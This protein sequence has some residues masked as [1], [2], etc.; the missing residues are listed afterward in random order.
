MISYYKRPSFLTFSILINLVLLYFTT[1]SINEVLSQDLKGDSRKSLVVNRVESSNN[2]KSDNYYLLVCNDGIS[3]NIEILNSFKTVKRLSSDSLIVFSAELAEKMP[4]I[5]SNNIAL[6][7]VNNNWKVS[8]NITKSYNKLLNGDFWLKITDRQKWEMFDDSKST[9]NTISVH[10]GYYKV[11]IDNL[12]FQELLN[13]SYITYIE[14]ASDTI[15]SEARVLD[16]NLNPN[17][18]NTIQAYFPDMDG[19]GEFVS[20]KEPFYEVDDIDLIGRYFDTGRESEFSDTHSLEMATIIAGNGN[21]FLTGLGVAPK[22]FHTSS[23]NSE[24]VPDP[25][26]YFASNKIQTQN[27]SYGTGIESFY[28]VSAALYD[29][30]VYENPSIIHVF[31]VGNSGLESSDHGKYEGLSGYSNITGNFK[32][33]KN[34]L[35]I[36]AVDTSMNIISLNSNGPAFDGR[37]KPE[38]VAYSMTGTSN[39]AALVSGV[40]VLL[41]QA[42]RDKYND[43][44]P[45]SLVKALLINSADEIGELGPDYRTGYGSMDGYGALLQL[46][47]EQFIH[48]E[49]SSSNEI[50]YKVN[51]PENAV[52]I[53]VS[54]VWTD[55][56]AEANDAIALI[57]DLNIEIKDEEGQVYLPWVLSDEPNQE[58]LNAPAVKGVDHLNNIE[59]IH[60]NKTNSDSLEIIISAE[61]ILE[62]VQSFSIV[63]DWEIENNFSWTSPTFKDNIPYNGETTSHLRWE[64]SYPDA[65]KGQLYFR[66][67]NGDSWTL[68]NEDIQLSD[69]NFRWDP[70]IVNDFVQ[71]KM[72]VGQKSY[73]SDTFSISEPLRLKVGYNCTDSLSYYWNSIP[74]VDNYTIYNLDGAEMKA[75]LNTQDTS[76]TINKSDLNSSYL[77]IQPFKNGRPLIQG[78]A[79]DYQ[80]QGSNCFLESYFVESVQEEGIYHFLKLSSLSG[81][82]KIKFEKRNDVENKWEVLS[83]FDA[84]SFEIEYL[85]NKPQNGFNTSR[86]VI[87]FTNG[88]SIVSEPQ[89]TYFVNSSDFIVYP[90][91]LL[92]G[93][94]LKVFAKEEN[95]EAIMSF[96]NLQGQE[97]LSFPVPKDRN[98]LDLDI[99]SPGLYMFRIIDRDQKLSQGKI[100]IQDY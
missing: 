38:L 81:V 34:I 46:E 39:S 79:I 17:R 18:I 14:K 19:K 49:L 87:D 80:L 62:D 71:L 2:I 84:G 72:D 66:I 99:L 57:N 50:K 61:N 67:I 85:E 83:E 42:Y 6:Y 30:Q 20:V 73:V 37:I 51:I 36:G 100:L 29:Q 55:P 41:Q 8:S 76:I 11:S 74:E 25:D 77:K 52:N 56:P 95:S 13:K 4:L 70:L 75:L 33:A 5:N 69:E 40:S 64:S 28:G 78:S 3:K 23:S 44:I 91:P 86:A 94:D 1:L 68:I 53:K 54:L 48:D 82:E 88:E 26:E 45:S 10:G 21:S 60:V 12:F 43:N 27:H 24:I 35:T 90:N 7:S 96:Y 9:I 93:D 31:S 63:Y 47:N 22:A 59:Q 16:L 32:Q 89:S 97:L 15:R 58:S 98:F 92:L 65:E